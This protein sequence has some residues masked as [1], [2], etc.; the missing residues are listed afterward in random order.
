MRIGDIKKLE[1]KH[2]DD[3][4]VKILD[5]VED[6]DDGKIYAEVEP[7]EF[8]SITREVPIELLKEV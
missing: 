6:P 8:K 7:V 5:L 2:G 4:I 3:F 1:N